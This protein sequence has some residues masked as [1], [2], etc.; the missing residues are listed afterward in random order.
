MRLGGCGRLLRSAYTSAKTTFPAVNAADTCPMLPLLLLPTPTAPK[1]KRLLTVSRRSSRGRSGGASTRVLIRC[2]CV[3]KDA[4][5]G[6]L[7]IDSS[8]R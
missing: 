1:T 7:R 5:E 3:E 2:P 8:P 4:S 6:A